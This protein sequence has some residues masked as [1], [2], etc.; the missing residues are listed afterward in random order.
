[1]V[2]GPCVWNI[3]LEETTP[4]QSLVI[5]YRHPKPCSS[6]VISRPRQLNQHLLYVLTAS[7]LCAKVSNLEAALWLRWLLWL[8][9]WFYSFPIPLRLGGWVALSMQYY[10]INTLIVI[11]ILNVL[12][13]LWYNLCHQTMTMS[14]FNT[15]FGIIVV[16]IVTV[17]L[18]LQDPQ[19]SFACKQALIRVTRPRPRHRRAHVS[20]PRCS[21]PGLYCCLPATWQTMC[22][23]FIIFAKRTEWMLETLFSFD[24][25]LSV[26]VCV[27][28]GAAVLNANGSKTSNLAVTFPGTVRT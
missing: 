11:L 26:C 5:F 19:V 7:S 14:L 4:A 21:S 1:M 10:M 25:C 12:C 2:A 13:V 28:L 8:I 16:F 23:A 3:L 9:D 22:S 27:C 6:K 15:V 24:V 20:P 17:V 18:L